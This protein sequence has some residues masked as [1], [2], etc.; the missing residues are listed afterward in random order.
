MT[1]KSLQAE[2]QFSE[3]TALAKSSVSLQTGNVVAAEYAEL[4]NAYEE[5][6]S[7]FE[8]LWEEKRV[9]CKKIVLL[10]KERDQALGIVSSKQ[11]DQELVEDLQEVVLDDASSD[12]ESEMEQKKGN[13]YE[14]DDDYEED[15]CD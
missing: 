1:Q 11:I 14:Y 3:A 8:Q 2:K 6:H 9:A 4:E 5:L 7:K 10:Q 15:S 13:D 12:E